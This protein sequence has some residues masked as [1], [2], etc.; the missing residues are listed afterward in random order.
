MRV[1]RIYQSKLD[2]ITDFNESLAFNRR[3]SNS[4]VAELTPDQKKQLQSRKDAA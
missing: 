2:E 4:D 3:V 1:D